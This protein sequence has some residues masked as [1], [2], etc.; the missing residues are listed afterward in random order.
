VINDYSQTALTIREGQLVFLPAYS[1]DFS[2]IEE[3]FSK[4]KA[5][6]RRVG[7]RTHE[8][9]FLRYRSSLAHF[10]SCRCTCLVYSLWLSGTHS[11]RVTIRLRYGGACRL[12]ILYI[13]LQGVGQKAA[14]PI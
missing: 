13:S 4:L 7:A 12:M 2:P 1:P 11:I 5:Y 6:L 8:T 10:H 3:A 14:L 9:L